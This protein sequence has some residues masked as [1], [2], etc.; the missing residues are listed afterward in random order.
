ML[1]K[2][3]ANA[4]VQQW[5]SLVDCAVYSRN[6]HFRMLGCCKAGK[7]ALLAPTRRYSCTPGSPGMHGRVA[8]SG[9]RTGFSIWVA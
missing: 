5:S 6:R 8:R 2:T 1:R 4:A 3:P 9:L 7:S